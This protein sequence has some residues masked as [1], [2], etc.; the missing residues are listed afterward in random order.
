MAKKSAA[1]SDETFARGVADALMELMGARE[2]SATGSSE[3]AA[4]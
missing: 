4:S 1:K 3:G 2:A